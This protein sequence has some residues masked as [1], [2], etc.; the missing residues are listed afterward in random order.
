V[1]E[2]RQPPTDPAVSRGFS[3]DSHCLLIGTADARQLE[4]GSWGLEAELEAT[5]TLTLV[6]LSGIVAALVYWFPVRQWYR[7]SGATRLEPTRAMSGDTAILVRDADSTLA[8]TI[9]ATPAE[10][11][12]SLLHFGWPRDGRPLYEWFGRAFGYLQPV[13]TEQGL[14]AGGDAKRAIPVGPGSEIPVVSVDPSR[15]LVLGQESERRR[16]TWQFE[17]STLNER[18]TRLILRSRAHVPSTFADRTF[19]WFSKG[20]SFVLTRKMLLDIKR[21]AEGTRGH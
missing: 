12:E 8:I 13:G 18:E 19:L 14:A 2:I 9:L 17:V 7:R 20:V 4:A 10:V 1:P 5:V 16:W 6:T 15:T 3:R 21:S 11:W